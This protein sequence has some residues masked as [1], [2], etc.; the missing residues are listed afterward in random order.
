MLSSVTG[1]SL[2]YVFDGLLVV[3]LPIMAVTAAAAFVETALWRRALIGLL[4][5]VAYLA[6]A[7]YGEASFKEPLVALMLL[8][9]VVYARELT[10]A[11]STRRTSVG[12]L[13]ACIPAGLLV[14]A[15]IDTYSD[16][17][18][19]WFAA[20]L[21]FWA[22]GELLA[23]PSLLRAP[24]MHWGTLRRGL[25]VALGAGLLVLVVLAPTAGRIITYAQ[26]LGT[27]P[28]ASGAIAK[29]MLGNL[30]GPLSPYEA[31]GVWLQP[32][33]R[34]VPANAFHA[35][36]LAAAALVV[37][38]F[39]L[40]WSLRRRD[41]ALP[42]LVVACAAVYWYSHHTQS[43]YVAAKTLMIASP[44]VMLVTARG[45]LT[46]REEDAGPRRWLVLR[47]LCGLAFALAA[48]FS[49]SL[50]L[51]ASHVMPQEQ[52]NELAAL[53]PLVGTKPTLFLGNDDFVGWEL[54]GV[55][56][57]YFDDASTLT[58]AIE[59][60]G[61]SEPWTYG[62]PLDFDSI[63]A[64][65]L[66]RFRYVITTSGAYASEP[67]SNFRLVRAERLY[68]LW[69]RHGS[70]PARTLLPSPGAP[71]AVVDCRTA[72]GRRLSHRDG[73]AAT[74]APP[75]SAGALPFVPAG[76]S[77]ATTIALPKGKWNISISY[78]SSETLLVSIGATQ[79]TMPANLARP[80]PFYAVGTVASSGRRALS[81]GVYEVHP[82]RLASSQD[83]GVVSALVA[84]RDPD[85]QSLVPLAKSCGRYVEWYQPSH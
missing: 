60:T 2:D 39:G 8:G 29:S 67:P 24:A 15:A 40:L 55:D 43:P 69:E 82:S 18:V 84:T 33:F 64:T 25:L 5:A 23:R 21:V 27:S 37:F 72:T 49:S 13:L 32:D 65:Q 19:G 34:F 28:A 22:A 35:G 1:L 66:D 77:A 36:E 52:V 42:A 74:F 51:R 45:L 62:Q 50:V 70:T 68:D 46:G 44:A 78:N 9:F 81:V 71:G 59:L 58:P 11:G 56:L 14:D 7:F 61:L 6:A 80:G 26:V 53:R 20:F 79:F 63:P 3:I 12:W 73:T 31:L 83:I 16:V 30:A 38:G 85:P 4:V 76:T 48:L 41:I 17:A 10:R 47:T 75:V 54:H 57:A